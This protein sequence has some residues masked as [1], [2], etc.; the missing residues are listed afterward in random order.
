MTINTLWL[1][2][3]D[4]L[5][6]LVKGGVVPR[7]AALVNIRFPKVTCHLLNTQICFAVIKCPKLENPLN[8]R[9]IVSSIDVSGNAFYECDIGYT[10]D[11]NKRKRI[12]QKVSDYSTVGVWSG[13]QPYCECKYLQSIWLIRKFVIVIWSRCDL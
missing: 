6:L 11:D 4:Q 5:A 13:D 10:M 2:V 12:C 8:G 1:E 9:V 7:L 3:S